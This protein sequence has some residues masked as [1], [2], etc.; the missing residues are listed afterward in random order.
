MCPRNRRPSRQAT[1]ALTVQ[2]CNAEAYKGIDY[3]KPFLSFPKRE[4]YNDA[5]TLEIICVAIDPRDASDPVCV[6]RELVATRQ[7]AIKSL[8]SFSLEVQQRRP[9]YVW[10]SAKLTRDRVPRLQGASDGSRFAATVSPTGT[11][12]CGRWRLGQGDAAL[13]RARR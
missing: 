3:G 10:A 7:D 1:R 12:T 8:A 9:R 2:F 13:V 4:F 11:G 5:A 6:M